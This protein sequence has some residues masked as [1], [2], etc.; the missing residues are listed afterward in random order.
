MTAVDDRPATEALGT[1]EQP[2]QGGPPVD[3]PDTPAA[4]TAEDALADAAADAT[5]AAVESGELAV[6]WETDPEVWQDGWA[7]GYLA[8]HSA[9]LAARPPR[10]VRVPVPIRTSLLAP[11]DLIED[12]KGVGRLVTDVCRA[13]AHPDPRWR[14]QQYRGRVVVTVSRVDPR[15]GVVAFDADRDEPAQ[16][17]I[18]VSE[19]E[20][21]RLTRD[22]LGARVMER[23]VIPA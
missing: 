14:A 6:V 8:G 1:D 4:V 22:Q 13:E 21:M 9:G 5:A 18:P 7:A 19:V 17:L 15:Q 3:W 16:V 2:E 23:R 20:A 10:S 11:G 12:R